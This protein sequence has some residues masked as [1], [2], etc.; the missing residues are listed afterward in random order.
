MLLGRGAY[1]PLSCADRHVARMKKY[2]GTK[3]GMPTPAITLS[4]TLK[5]ALSI[6]GLA[7][8]VRRH[9]AEFNGLDQATA[10]CLFHAIEKLAEDLI[11]PPCE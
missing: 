4:E 5:D 7:A 8:L 1:S 2:H 3:L 11:N 6:A 9:A 10:D